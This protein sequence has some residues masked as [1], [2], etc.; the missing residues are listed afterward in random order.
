MSR[1]PHFARSRLGR[2]RL[3]HLGLAASVQMRSRTLSGS[4]VKPEKIVG[5]VME[6]CWGLGGGKSCHDGGK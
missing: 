4:E 5:G 1:V 3:H 2:L 6:F